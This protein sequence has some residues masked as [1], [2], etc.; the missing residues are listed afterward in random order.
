MA[1]GFPGRAARR[2]AGA[3]PA[4]QSPG[5]KQRCQGGGSGA[6][7]P[8]TAPKFIID[9]A[10][11]SAGAG[12]KTPRLPAPA[13]VALSKGTDPPLPNAAYLKDINSSEVTRHRVVSGYC[14]R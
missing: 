5:R 1:Q 7:V 4:E 3:L 8:R 12:T 2:R 10:V 9:R 6:A 14:R 13:F 11:S